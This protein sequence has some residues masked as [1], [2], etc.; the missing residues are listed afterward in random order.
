MIRTT[1]I[2]TVL[3]LYSFSLSQTLPDKYHTYAEGIAEL[4]S[5]AGSHPGI[6]SLDSVG[7][8]NRDSLTIYLFKIS[9]NVS[10][11]EDEPAIFFNGGVHADEVLSVEVVLNFCQDIIAQYDSGNTAVQ[12]YVNDY[13]IFV[14]PFTNPEG[15]TVVEGGDTEWR[16]NKTDNDGNGIFD[17]HDGVDPNRNYDFGWDLDTGPEATTPESLTY[18]GPYP[19]SESETRTVRNLGILYKPIIAVD[20]HSPT[21]GR[22][23]VLYYCWYWDIYGFAPDELTMRHI[24]QEFGAMIVTDSGDSTYEARR[25]LVN[26]GDFKTYYYGNFG[27]AAFVVE[28]SDTTIQDTSM[29]DGICERHLPGMYYLLERAGYARLSGIAT[30]SLTGLPLEAEVEVLEATGPEINPRYTRANTGRYD[31]LIDPGTY[32]LRFQKDGYITKTVSGVVVSNLYVTYTDVQLLP[33][34]VVP[35]TPQL[36]YPPDQIVYYD[37]THLSFD[38]SSSAFAEEYII[39][40]ADN[41]QF[42]PIF[43]ED[44]NLVNSDYRNISPFAQERYY[45]RVTASNSNGYSDRSEVWVFNIVSSSA[46]AAPVLISPPDSFESS[47]PYLDFDWSDVADAD[48]YAIEIASDQQFDNVVESDSALTL[49]EYQNVDSLPDDDYYWRARAGNANGW[50]LY[51]EVWTFSVDAEPNIV[52]IPGDVNHSGDVNGLDVIY[53][54]NYFKGGPPPP[55]EVEGFYPEADANGSCDVNGL[56]VLYLVNFFKGGSPPIDGNCLD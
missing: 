30:D 31:R 3:I 43:E 39:E 44:S 25:G 12:G 5:L 54:V 36:I 22:P 15:H 49:S 19:F 11:E 56:D 7:Y 23:E 9:D 26:K 42:S 33:E 16:K 13:E 29:V 46:P 35:E 34:N 17:F 18:K 28:I 6:C 10:L 8:S 48:N 41:E 52:Y 50:S 4:D 14:V 21:Y 27:T 40:I 32:S 20:Y 2:L 55:L 45:W 1:T 51:S 37:S 24:G 53:L 38:W 47:A